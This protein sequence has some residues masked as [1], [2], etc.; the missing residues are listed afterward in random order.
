MPSQDK[1]TGALNVIDY[2]HIGLD[3]YEHTDKGA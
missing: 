3:W 1:S 2:D